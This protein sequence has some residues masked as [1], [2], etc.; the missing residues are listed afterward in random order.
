M[1][2]SRP[3]LPLGGAVTVP[4][5]QGWQDWVCPNCG[6]EE[7]TPQLP[8]N[9][10][11]FHNCPGL[12]GLTAPLLP[13]GISAKVVAEARED[14]L[15]GETQAT[16]DDGRPYMAVRTVRDDGEDLIVNAGLARGRLRME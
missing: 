14:Y 11:R 5:L 6:L 13:V 10:S 8:P 2:L 9:S 15:N 1:Q 12:H 7:R 16:G 3:G 4:L